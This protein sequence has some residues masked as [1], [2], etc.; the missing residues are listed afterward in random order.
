[1]DSDEYQSQND[2]DLELEEQGGSATLEPSA[3][4]VGVPAPFL[5][6][7]SIPGWKDAPQPLPEGGLGLLQSESH[8]S[9]TDF[10][11]PFPGAAL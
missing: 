7:A 9:L 6:T 8:E 3:V 11:L 1:M 2:T 10:V 4:R 5:G